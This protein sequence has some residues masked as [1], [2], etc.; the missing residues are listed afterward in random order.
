MYERI[1]ILLLFATAANER[2]DK[3]LATLWRRHIINAYERHFN[4]SRHGVK[5]KNRI[6]VSDESRLR[7]IPERIDLG[8]GSFARVSISLFPALTDNSF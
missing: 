4:N 8:R 3:A 7:I 6:E 2:K 1:G 5:L